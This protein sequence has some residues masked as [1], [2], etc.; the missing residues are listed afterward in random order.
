MLLNSTSFF[1]Y[2]AQ[3]HYLDLNSNQLS[4]SLPPFSNLHNLKYLN[5]DENHLVG[6]VAPNLCFGRKHPLILRVDCEFVSCVCCA[7]CSEEAQSIED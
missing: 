1:G 7:D 4:G 5:V 2:I 6:T 3:L